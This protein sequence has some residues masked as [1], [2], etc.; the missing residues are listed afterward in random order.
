MPCKH[1]PIFPKS[2]QPWQS[3]AWSHS[4]F[5]LTVTSLWFKWK[6]C[7]PPKFTNIKYKTKQKPLFQRDRFAVKYF[8]NFP[9]FPLAGNQETI[10]PCL[11]LAS[12]GTLGTEC[13]GRR[14]NAR[15]LF[16]IRW[17]MGV[18]GGGR[19]NW[20]LLRRENRSMRSSQWLGASHNHWPRKGTLITPRS[21]A[22]EE[23]HF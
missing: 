3:H 8:K 7:V 5:S 18:A 22:A 1:S 13:E 10:F 11:S 6:T 12:S 23:P 15:W 20:L 9:L 21:L 14:L 16:Q 4:E 2:S 19:F 17:R